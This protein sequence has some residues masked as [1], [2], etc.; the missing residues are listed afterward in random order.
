M[1][2]L[3]ALGVLILLAACGSSAG[4][5]EG[6]P[7]EGL[8]TVHWTG[9]YAGSFSAPAV[10]R[11][12]ASD[13]LIEILAVRGDTGI[14][15]VLLGQDSVRTGAYQVYLPSVFSAS[16][17]QAHAVARWLGQDAVLGFEGKGGR[18]VLTEAGDRVTGR[19]DAALRIFH[20]STP[21]TLQLVGEFTRIP[22]QSATPPCSRLVKPAGS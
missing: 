7:V 4:P 3:Q 5:A 14:G 17:P 2:R 15:L 19:I 11:W 22:V 9:S 21:D 16:R 20:E 1:L 10:G 8:L 12:C 18:V 6:A 13:S